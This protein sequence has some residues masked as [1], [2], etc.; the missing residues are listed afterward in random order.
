MKPLFWQLIIGMFLIGQFVSYSAIGLI[1]PNS[2]RI[3]LF[4]FAKD[5][6]AFAQLIAYDEVT[7]RI[8]IGWRSIW[9]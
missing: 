4:M 6:F 8:Q 9:F 1:R 5:I 3:R 7:P 2:V